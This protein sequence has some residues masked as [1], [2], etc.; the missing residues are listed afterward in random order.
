MR[1]GALVTARSLKTGDCV[2]T[3]DGHDTVVETARAITDVGGASRRCQYSGSKLQPTADKNVGGTADFTL[4]V[5]FLCLLGATEANMR[6]P[7]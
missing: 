1:K 6:M 4:H 3:E 2:M 5:H 7:A